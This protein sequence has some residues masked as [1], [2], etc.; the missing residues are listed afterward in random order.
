MQPSIRFTR[1]TVKLLVQH[2]KGAYDAGALRSVRR[3]SALLGLAKGESVKQVAETISLSRQEP[4][5]APY[6]TEVQ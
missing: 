4:I 2:L 5:C 3:I 6:S 1:P